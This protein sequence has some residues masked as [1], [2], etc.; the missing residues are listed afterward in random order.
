MIRIQETTGTFAG[1]RVLKRGSKY[2][3]VI[4]SHL[5]KRRASDSVGYK[6]GNPI[7][8]FRNRFVVV[9]DITKRVL[10]K[11]PDGFKV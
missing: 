3:V 6:D 7:M 2:L 1:R 8:R 4:S 9:Q 11:Y 5:K 10:E